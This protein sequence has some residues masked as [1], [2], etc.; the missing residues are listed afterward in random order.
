MNGV[1]A[2]NFAFRSQHEI[3]EKCSVQTQQEFQNVQV[4][5]KSGQN[6]EIGF[7]YM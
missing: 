4:G 3:V 2:D 6:I 1:I 5:N 7:D